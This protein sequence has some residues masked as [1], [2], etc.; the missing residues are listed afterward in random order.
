MKKL[1]APVLLTLA[2]LAGCG[3]THVNI[4]RDVHNAGLQIAHNAAVVGARIGRP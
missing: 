3:T 1:I 2:L 4:G